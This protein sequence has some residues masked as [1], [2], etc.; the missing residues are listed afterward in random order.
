[1]NRVITVPGSPSGN[2][3]SNNGSALVV[4]K[5][6][7]NKIY[8]R[9]VPFTYAPLDFTRKQIR[10]LELCGA[11][12]GVIRC[13]LR[14]VEM[15]HDNRSRTPYRALSYT[16]GPEKPTHP[17]LIN[18]Q[19]F[20][21]RQNLYDFLIMASDRCT[22]TFSGELWIDQICIDQDTV[23]EKNHQVSMMASI[24]ENADEAVVWLG[25]LTEEQEAIMP[26]IESQMAAEYGRLPGAFIT[27]QTEPK[28]PELSTVIGFFQNPY[29]TRMW[30]VQELTVSCD[31][32][33]YG[34]HYTLPGYYLRCFAVW[35]DD[36][37]P[38]VEPIR[39]MSPHVMYLLTREPRG[40]AH[41]QLSDLLKH[42][43]GGLCFD[44]KDRVYALRALLQKG[45]SLV[46]D[47]SKPNIDVL[48][49]AVRLIGEETIVRSKQMAVIMEGSGSRG[50]AAH[51]VS[52]DL[53]KAFGLGTSRQLFEKLV[54]D[55][56][57]EWYRAYQAGNGED[58]VVHKFRQHFLGP[59]RTADVTGNM[60]M[61]YREPN[62][63]AEM[64]AF[65][66]AREGSD[67]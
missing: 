44:T 34:A 56:D 23:V 67:A 48:L 20:E 40:A 60:D 10:V 26:Y 2:S 27:Y 61:G 16:W 47:Y 4:P 24:Y 28:G 52:C 8:A 1:M 31:F 15:G 45:N 6:E 11:T 33:V 59:D 63:N 64:N 43:D 14:T 5:V 17:I 13:K 19:V 12:D 37:I 49:D 3:N 32:T 53:P 41:Y 55:E 30:I 50:L 9:F 29:W 66:R 38:E 39:L 42:L 57:D 58:W 62:F 51:A 35:L 46:V 22:T 18:D 36:H 25:G 65:I 7:E 21:V 54:G